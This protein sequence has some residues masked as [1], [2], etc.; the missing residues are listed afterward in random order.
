VAYLAVNEI[1][2]RL[3]LRRTGNF[4][5]RGRAAHAFQ[6]NDVGEMQITQRALKFFALHLGSQKRVHQID[7]VRMRK[8][9]F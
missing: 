1:N 8:R 9:F 2:A 5:D 4:E 6:L 7:E 3:F